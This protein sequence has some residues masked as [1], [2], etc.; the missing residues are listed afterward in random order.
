MVDLLWMWIIGDGEQ[1]SSGKPIVG[2]SWYGVRQR[3]V[4]PICDNIQPPKALVG[5]EAFLIIRILCQVHSGKCT[6][7]YHLLFGRVPCQ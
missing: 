4:R 2:G 7:R 6:Q 1:S 5:R 3:A